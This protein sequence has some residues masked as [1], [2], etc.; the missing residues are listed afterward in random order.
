MALVP[1]HTMQA[2]AMLAWFNSHYR[3][4]RGDEPAAHAVLLPRRV[5]RAELNNALERVQLPPVAERSNLWIDFLRD[6]LLVD[7]RSGKA[8]ALVPLVALDAFR[9]T[10]LTLLAQ[11]D[12]R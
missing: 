7:A 6:V 5:L 10:L 1:V 9:Q 2:A 11:L 12:G 4:P 8:V 3:L